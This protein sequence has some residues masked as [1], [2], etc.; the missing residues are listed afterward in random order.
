[1]KALI[2]QAFDRSILTLCVRYILLTI[3][4]YRQ[5]D[6]DKGTVSAGNKP[7]QLGIQSLAFLVTV[8]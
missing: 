5:L 3:K 8:C 2:I 1:M 4:V 7:T 6:T